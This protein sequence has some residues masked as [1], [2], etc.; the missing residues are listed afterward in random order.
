MPIIVV[1]IFAAVFAV[2]TLLADAPDA[3]AQ[4]RAETQIISASDAGEMLLP[5]VASRKFPGRYD[6]SPRRSDELNCLT[7][8]TPNAE[9][10]ESESRGKA[11]LE[12]KGNALV[13]CFLCPRLCSRHMYES[14]PLGSPE[15]YRRRGVAPPTLNPFSLTIRSSPL[16]I[17]ALQWP[18]GI[19]L[20]NDNNSEPWEVP[21]WRPNSPILTPP[22]PAQPDG[23]TNQ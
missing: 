8:L 1:L 3:P 9:E 5:E 6:S 18:R 7:G 23:G 14:S 2:G 16:E 12:A 13:D 22:S 20:T 19:F 17:P 4:E 10:S 21:V 15:L 11:V